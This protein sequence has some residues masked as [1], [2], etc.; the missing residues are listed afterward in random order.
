VRAAVEAALDPVDPRPFAVE[1]RVRRPDGAARWVESHG[2]ATFE[3][4][5]T[6]RRASS[7]VGTV[8][9]VTDR[10]R[11]EDEIRRLNAE[12]ED[13]VRERT[14]QLAAANEDLQGFAHSVSHDLRAPLRGIDGWSLALL[15][16]CSERLDD[17][18][19]GHL[20]RVRAEAQRMGALIDDLLG[21]AR[22]TRAEM[23]SSP[24]D[25]SAVAAAVLDRLREGGPG[26]I[27]EV[28]IEPGLEARGDRAL[29][30]IALTNLLENAWKF[31]GARP[32]ARIEVGRLRRDGREVFFVRDNGAGFDMAYAGKLFG[33]FQRLHRLSEFP[34]TGIGLAT[35]QRIIRRHGGEVW[36]ES[37]PERGATFFFTLAEHA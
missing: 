5:G 2:I 32:A 19:R 28:E 12:L 9:D 1:Y 25:L 23:R 20:A 35:V 15:E 30:E 17:Q 21:L 27:V 13:R 37:A 10:K 14:A 11:K 18:G 6:A 16:D 24:V 7:F 22:V 33:A 8:E 34:G 31:T 29:L 4:E 36:A 3:G 26:R